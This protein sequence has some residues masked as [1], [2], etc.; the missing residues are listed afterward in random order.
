MLLELQVSN[1][2]LIENLKLSFAPGLNILSGETGAGKSI[3]IGALNLIL[4]ER[5]AVEQIRQGQDIALIEGVISL[6]QPLQAKIGEKLKDAGIEEADELLIGREV[7]R[8]GR[9]VARVNGRSVPVSFLKEIGKLLFDLHG[10][11]QHQSLLRSEQHSELLDSFGGDKIKNCKCGLAQLWQKQQDLKKELSALGDDSAERE[12]RLDVYAFQLK[13]I[14]EAN[15]K[16]GEDSELMQR[17]RILANSEKLLKIVSEAYNEI[18]AGEENGPS[19]SIM[20]KVNRICGSLREASGIDSTIV[21]LP[22]LLENASAQMEEASHELRSYRDKLEYDPAELTAIQ[23]RVNLINALKRKYGGS[24]EDVLEFAE[25]SAQEMERLKN[26]EA[27]AMELEN[28]I[29]ELEKDIIG[30]CRKLSDLRAQTAKTLEGLLEECLK[31]LA[32]P[33][34]VFKVQIREKKTYT[35]DGIDNIEFLFSANRGEEAKPLAKVIS[36]GEASRVMLAMKT[37]LADQDLVPTLIFDEIDSGI[38][39]ATIQAVAEKLAGLAAKH[40]VMCVTHSPQIAAM[41]DL[42]YRLYKETAGER[43]LTQAVSLGKD[44]RREELARMLD[45]SNV[46]QVGLQHVDSLLKRA[47]NYKNKI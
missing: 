27:L 12:R 34:A 40:Q 6:N 24:I 42:H 8:N 4:G 15:I 18:Y 11:H 33:N 14:T 7:F 19:E 23:E 13:E 37:A 30:L 20:D 29:T 22:E 38:G 41:S 25:K 9:S 17:E 21:H 39:G 2:A 35:A 10:Q 1:Y 28:K 44:E 32:L 3:V 26:S 45:G 31:E 46:D 43:T 5:A 47:L 16:A 36:G